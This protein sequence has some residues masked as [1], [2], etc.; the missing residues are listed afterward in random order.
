MHW[1]LDDHV[2]ML[3]HVQYFYNENLHVELELDTLDPPV[4]E[5]LGYEARI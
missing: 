2:L 5:L 1:M 4:N 3:K